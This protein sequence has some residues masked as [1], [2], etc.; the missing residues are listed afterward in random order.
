MKAV[1]DTWILCFRTP[2][3]GFYADNKGEF[4]NIKMD[5]LFARL[6][7]TIRYGH[8]PAYSP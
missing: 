2:T 5:E 6:G 1:M 4:V 8:W 7:V 3:V